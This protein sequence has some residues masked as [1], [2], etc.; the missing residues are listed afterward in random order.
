[1]KVSELGEFGL[2]DRLT[3]VIAPADQHRQG[4]PLI[5]GIGDD[6]AAWQGDA[7]VQLATIDCLVQDVHF[8]LRT[9]TWQDVGWKALA[10]NLSD[11]AAMGGQPAY[12]L[13]SLALPGD[14]EV[15]DLL[16]L[17]R[18][19]AALAEKFDVAIIGG[20]TVS[21][22]QLIV[23]VALFGTAVAK[24][25]HLLT[26]SASRPGDRVAVTGSLGAAAAGVEMLAKGLALGPE[27]T[28]SLRQACL[29]PWPRLAEG[30]LLVEQGVRAAIDISDGLL[31][32][33][34][35][36]CRASGVSARVEAERVPVAP[37]VMDSFADRALA[38]AVAGGEDFELLFTATAEI[39]ARVSALISVPV[40]VIGEIT[41]G[42]GDT[43]L[44]DSRGA[45]VSLPGTGWD[46]F[47]ARRSQQ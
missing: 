39:I 31:S 6:A 18:G 46:H 30:R 44:V 19:M 17:Y 41:E 2:I 23:D 29:R 9:A 12:A 36:I 26:R 16:D 34:N 11:I 10:V 4:T 24:G 40:T 32:D 1:M 14:T 15:D 21:A 5:V 28:A 35:H 42:A 45:P 47:R 37:L 13:V 20:N 7:S 27:A 33:L 25:C 8:S 43:V 3:E 22:P 38:L